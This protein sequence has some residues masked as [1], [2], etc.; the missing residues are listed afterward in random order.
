MESRV[1]VDVDSLFRD[2]LG[3][4]IELMGK[5]RAFLAVVDRAWRATRQATW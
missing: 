3:R 1:G 5:R 4:P 2:R